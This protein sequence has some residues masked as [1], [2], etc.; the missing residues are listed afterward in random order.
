M[1]ATQI[2][3]EVKVEGNRL[4]WILLEDEKGIVASG[5]ALDVDVARRRAW[6]AL[7]EYA[8]DNEAEYVNYM[9]A[10]KETKT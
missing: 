8:T 4:Q 9:S 1:N 10:R 5:T 6:R 2:R 7:A 3:L